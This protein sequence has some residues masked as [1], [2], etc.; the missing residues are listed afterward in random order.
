MWL[1]HSDLFHTAHRVK[2]QQVGKSR[3]ERCG[4]IELAA[5][6]SNSERPVSLV[7]DLRIVHE[8]WGSSSK[9]SLNGHLHCPTDID[10]TLNE[11]AADKVLQYRAD[12]NN[13][14]SHVITFI[15]AIPSTSA[16]LHSEFVL[17]FL[18]VH[19]ETDRFRAASGVQ[20]AQSAFHFRRAAFSS[21][22]KSKVDHV[23]NKTTALRINLNIDDTL[24]VPILKVTSTKA[25]WKEKKN[26][27]LIEGK[28]TNSL[29]FEN[30]QVGVRYGLIQGSLS[31]FFGCIH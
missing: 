11:S 5:Y 21:Q 13:R 26:T 15:H 29:Q 24:I 31:S 16:R 22:L 27:N 28:R 23:L 3:G 18:Q 19:R 14:P 30:K 4:N 9:P 12:Y 2:T 17:L 10:R 7:L 20:I 1:P 25:M 6:L 8:R